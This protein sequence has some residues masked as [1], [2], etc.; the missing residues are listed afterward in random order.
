MVSRKKEDCCT[1]SVRKAE[2]ETSGTN[3][4]SEAE[5]SVHNTEPQVWRLNAAPR[6]CCQRGGGGVTIWSCFTATERRF[7]QSPDLKRTEV[8]RWDMKVVLNRGVFRISH[9]ASAFWL[10]F[11]QIMT[12]CN[13]WLFICGCLNPFNV[14]FMTSSHVNPLN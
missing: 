6:V 10:R 12:Q 3:H 5:T 2:N 8:L 14:I 11:S 7:N 13:V 9:T 1:S 4:E